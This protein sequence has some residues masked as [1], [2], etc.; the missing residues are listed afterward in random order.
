MSN[1]A[2]VYASLRLFGVSARF[3]LHHMSK[4]HLYSEEDKRATTN[5][6]NGSVFRKRGEYGFGEYGFK[7]RAQ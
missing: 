6:Q 5:V 2:L 3:Y 4:R 1:L 7:H